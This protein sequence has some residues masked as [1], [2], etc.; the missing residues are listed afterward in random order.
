MAASHR[1]WTAFNGHRFFFLFLYLMASLVFYPFVREGTVGY[2]IF[3]VA[4]SAGILLTVYVI[5]MRRTILT[6]ALLLA[7]PA[8]F[9]RMVPLRVDVMGV[10][11]LPLFNTALS[12]AFD[13]LVVVII[14]RRV[15]TKEEPKS[16]T[17]FGALCIYLLVGFSFASAYGMVAA[18]QH[19]AFYLNPLSNLHTVPERFDFVYYSFAIITSLGAAGM[20]PVSPQARSLSVIEAILGILYLAVLISRL[21]SA[22]KRQA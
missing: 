17:I 9:E 21:V 14:F 1:D 3:R 11:F 2:F 13:V 12:F 4:G 18:L 10:R 5:S 15:F 8:L 20:V 19:G 22:Y 16:E 7:I 6:A